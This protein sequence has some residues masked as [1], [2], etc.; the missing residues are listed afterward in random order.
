MITKDGF[1][2]TMNTLIGVYN[3]E[4]PPIEVHQ[5]Y[6]SIFNKNFESDEELMNA[7]L[8]VLENRVFPSFPKPAE[9]LE[10][11][12][13][14]N[15]IDSEITHEIINLRSALK[16]YGAYRNVCFD[17]PIMHKVIQSLFSSWVK[18]C[19][20]E[21]EKFEEIIKWDFPKAYKFYREQKIKEVPLFLEGIATHSNGLGNQEERIEICY[22]GNEEK[23]KKWNLVYFNKN[24]LELTNKEKAK[25]LGFIQEEKPQIEYVQE[26]K[27]VDDIIGSL[28]IKRIEKP[29]VHKIEY[30][31]E[32]LLNMLKKSK[33]E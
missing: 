26:F 27:T 3:K 10:A 5:V 2:N 31:K 13:L 16:K 29:K 20:M 11:C 4:L 30:T 15:D 32:E 12:K 17:N 24:K 9:F 33:E 19:R 28:E 8:K 21:I 1:N 18:C 23:C 7:T 22:V 6:F 25:Q 14:K